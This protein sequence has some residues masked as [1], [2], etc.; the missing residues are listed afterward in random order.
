[1]NNTGSTE[2]YQKAAELSSWSSQLSAIFLALHLSLYRASPLR[3][4]VCRTLVPVPL[5]YLRIMF[6]TWASRTLLTL[7]AVLVFHLRPFFFLV[8]R[9]LRA[10]RLPSRFSP[11]HE[12]RYVEWPHPFFSSF[13]R[14]LRSSEKS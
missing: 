12:H 9:P 14:A 5:L 8:L 13:Y 10:P 6:I 3:E 1:M 2:D 4:R 11:G 7:S